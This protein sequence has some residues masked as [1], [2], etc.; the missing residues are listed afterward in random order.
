MDMAVSAQ[1]ALFKNTKR[2]RADSF[3]LWK[4]DTSLAKFSGLAII[5]HRSAE[6]PQ[7]GVKV[8]NFDEASASLEALNAAFSA[9][10]NA[11]SF[12]PA[13][14]PV[15]HLQLLHAEGDTNKPRLQVWARPAGEGVSGTWSALLKDDKSMPLPNPWRLGFSSYSGTS[16]GKTACGVQVTSFHVHSYE[17]SAG[18]A[19]KEYLGNLQGRV[20]E[21]KIQEALRGIGKDLNAEYVKHAEVMA[22]T[23]EQLQRL[24]RQVAQMMAK[25]DGFNH[26]AP[27]GEHHDVGALLHVL[28]QTKEQIETDT[29]KVAH[30]FTKKKEEQA[31]K[32]PLEKD[33]DEVVTKLDS[34]VEKHGRGSSFSS[35]IFLA[36]AMGACASVYKKMRTYEKKHHL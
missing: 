27:G 28:K 15:L 21:E 31:K 23:R 17:L 12:N 30:E 10:D 3:P 22:T 1:A 24:E 18:A 6:T 16:E 20:S 34:T 25:V 5:A 29:T 7:V 8:V 4:A 36:V 19:S 14:T 13:K 26:S 9:K 2:N 33:F 11:L 32:K 35:F